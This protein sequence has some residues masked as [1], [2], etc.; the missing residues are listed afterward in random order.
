MC[1]LPVGWM[2]ERTRAFMLRGGDETFIVTV[3]KLVYG[4]EGLGR[5]DGRVVLVPYVM[6]GERVRWQQFR[7]EKG[8][9]QARL[10]EILEPST[11]TRPPPCPYFGRCG[12]CHYQHMPYEWQLSEKAAI[13]RRNL[14]ASARSSHRKIYAWSRASRGNIETA[15][16]FTCFSG[17]IGY[18]EARSH[19]LCPIDHVP[20]RHRHQR[21]DG[22]AHRNAAR[23][24]VAAFSAFSRS[25]YE[26]NQVQLNVLEADRPIAKVF[27]LVRRADS[28]LRAGRPRICGGWRALSSEPGFVLSGESI[29]G[30]RDGRGGAR[31]H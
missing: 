4:G 22:N 16:S 8:M 5:V 13:L 18:L 12:G 17:A 21:S 28:G 31:R 20:S 10:Q 27:R 25:I 26:R 9:V 30:G 3:E 23:S 15:R 2:P 29:S 11:G 14:R 24:P 19:K 1:R 6:P 7:S